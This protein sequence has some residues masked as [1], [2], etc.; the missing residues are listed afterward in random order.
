MDVARH[1]VDRS[2]KAAQSPISRCE[3]WPSR[4]RPSCTLTCW[5]SVQSIAVGDL[6]AFLGHG[7]QH[8]PHQ[9]ESPMNRTPLAFVILAFIGL[10]L[11]V[12][13]SASA[14]PVNGTAIA[15]ASAG[16]SMFTEVPCRYRRV[17]DYRGCRSVRRCW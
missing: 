9:M 16:T 5:T 14:A 8:I 1:F 2:V 17:C 11:M 6:L 15:K 10:G 4:T 13:P 3:Q 12:L 7:L